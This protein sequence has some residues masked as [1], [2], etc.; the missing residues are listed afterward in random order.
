MAESGAHRKG[1]VSLIKGFEK[2]R[3]APEPRLPG[4]GQKQL[5]GHNRPPREARG[6]GSGGSGGITLARHAVHLATKP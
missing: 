3:Q 1:D 5:S 6:G 4:D 2:R